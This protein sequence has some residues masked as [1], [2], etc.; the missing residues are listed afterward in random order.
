MKKIFF[1][2]FCFFIYQSFGQ[3]KPTIVKN[4]A[5][6][7]QELVHN[8]F[9]YT[10]AE[11]TIIN[12]ITYKKLNRLIPNF[13]N[14]TTSYKTDYY[15]RED[16]G[17]VYLKEKYEIEKLIYD[18]NLM[19]GDSFNIEHG[20]V[21]EKRKLYRI[22]STQLNDNR[23]YKVYFFDSADVIEFALPE[24]IWIEGIGSLVSLIYPNETDRRTTTKCFIEN[25]IKY[26]G[27]KHI[28]DC[29]HPLGIE[30][31]KKT[32]E[33][34]LNFTNPIKDNFIITLNKKTNGC[35]A[36][37]DLLGNIIYKD[38]FYNNNIFIHTINWKA[39]LYNLVITTDQTKTYTHKILRNEY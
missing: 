26:Y 8:I 22:D 31:T 39:G 21:I 20:G 34:T 18:F 30:D 19:A 17:S 5:I 24:Y 29:F 38:C 15:L 28:A 25:N 32:D 35:V 6:W 27:S 23:Y 14:G 3:I 2:S 13:D 33:L 9:G 4:D 7:V 1:I 11:D 37:Y 10:F 16:S 12:N 36:I